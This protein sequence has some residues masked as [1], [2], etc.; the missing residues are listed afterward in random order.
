[1]RRFGFNLVELL[2]VIAIIAVLLGML[3]PA[4]QIVRETGYRIR[5][6]NNLKQIGLACHNYHD[7]YGALPEG[8][9]LSPPLVSVHVQLL[10]YLEQQAR[11]DQLNSSLVSTDPSSFYMRIGDVPIYICPSDPS[12]AVV[13]ETSASTPP[14]ASPGPDG[15][16]NY[17]ANLGAHAWIQDYGT[18]ANTF[19]QK[20]PK[21]AGVFGTTTS[22]TAVYVPFYAITDGLAETALFAEIKRGTNMTQFLY[23]TG[24]MTLWGTVNT[25][26]TTNLNN[27]APVPANL[28]AACNSGVAPHAT[29]N[30]VTGL[31]YFYGQSIYALYTH[32]LPPN[33]TGTDCAYGVNQLHFASRS[34]HPGGVNVVLCDGSV[35]FI[36]T[37][38]AF[39]IWQALGTRAGGETEP[40]EN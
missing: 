21:L 32:T 25:N 14:G 39:S 30:I 27:E 4:I 40:F 10:P 13:N 22:T 26:P 11:Y 16:S 33:Y 23:G 31:Q 15:R 3:L 1:M 19:V 5:C 17:Y 18:V 12:S 35:H 20:N 6:Q 7:T 29:S 9:S 24:V 2:V 28:V 36:S 38:I 37:T 8:L 34:C